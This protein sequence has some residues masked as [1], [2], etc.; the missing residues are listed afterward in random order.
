MSPKFAEF[1]RRIAELKAEPCVDCRQTFAPRAL[2][3]DHVRGTK[4][5]AVAE[6]REFAWDRVVEEIAK[7]DL[8]CACC[9]RKRT[10]ARRAG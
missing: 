2:D 4:L 5:R 1:H 6:M 10:H 8:V 9:H 3:F 7:C